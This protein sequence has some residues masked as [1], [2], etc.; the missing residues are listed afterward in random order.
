M[1]L[2]MQRSTCKKNISFSNSIFLLGPK[3]AAVTFLPFVAGGRPRV[4]VFLQSSPLCQF[5]HN[6]NCWDFLNAAGARLSSIVGDV[7]KRRSKRKRQSGLGNNEHVARSAH[8]R[9]ENAPPSFPCQG[10]RIAPPRPKRTNFS[11]FWIIL[12]RPW[13]CVVKNICFENFLISGF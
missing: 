7:K 5:F 3:F 8:C 10:K 11:I 9:C 13:Y 6:L 1:C 12:T 4:F 2:T